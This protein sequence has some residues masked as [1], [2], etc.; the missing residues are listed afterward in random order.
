MT[1]LKKQLPL[2]LAA[3]MV[4]GMALV[5]LAPVGPAT[6]KQAKPAKN[7]AKQPAAVVSATG[8]LVKVT[9]GNDMRYVLQ[10]ASGKTVYYLEAGPKWYCGTA[11]YPLDKYAGQ[12]V[13]VTGVVE[14][15]KA[16]KPPKNPKANQ[17][18]KAPLDAP[19]LEVYTINND[20]IRDAGKPPWAGGPKNNPNH[21][22]NNGNANGNGNGK[23]KATAPG[24]NK[25]KGNKP[26]K[27]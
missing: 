9:V 3:M 8:K 19:M 14:Q 27:P 5:T 2:L 17:A 16:N 13:T 23:G 22:G 7:E 10:D 12:Q 1:S 11:A 26:V 15:P 25:D 18:P 4:A 20:K 6:A 24:Q 21:P